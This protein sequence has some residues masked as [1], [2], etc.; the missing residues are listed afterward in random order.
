V[1]RSLGRGEGERAGYQGLIAWQRAMD[2][3]EAVYATTRGW[4][5]EELYGLTGQ[6]RRAAISIPSNIAEGHGRA[7]L[8]EYIHHVSVAYGSL[9]ELETQVLIAQRLGY[10]PDTD[11]RVLLM[12]IS[13][14]RRLLRGLLE[15]LRERSHSP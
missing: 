2:L 10:H 5:R 15:K 7:G 4:P 1:E 8:K 3:V 11:T 6:A 13:E 12:Q 9:S 14:V